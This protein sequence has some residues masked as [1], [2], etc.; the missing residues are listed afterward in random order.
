M[1]KVRGKS[2]EVRGEAVAK[3]KMTAEQKACLEACRSFEADINRAKYISSIYSCVLREMCKGCDHAKECKATGET[4]NCR[5]A[6][7]ASVA[8][9]MIEEECK[10]NLET[11]REL[12]HGQ[13]AAL[14]AEQEGGAK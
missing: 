1:K 2:E 8:V 9:G 5:M 10:S 7:I 3:P 11:S 6:A 13:M 12:L 14:N 4:L